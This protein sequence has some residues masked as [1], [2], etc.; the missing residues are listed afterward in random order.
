VQGQ[1]MMSHPSN[2]F[3][4]PYSEEMGEF[5]NSGSYSLVDGDEHAHKF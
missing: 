5:Q 3:F 1:T 4:S 2:L